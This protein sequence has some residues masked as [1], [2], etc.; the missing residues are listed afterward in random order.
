MAALTLPHKRGRAFL[1]EIE[2]PDIVDGW[3]FSSAVRVGA[4][5]QA[6]RCRPIHGTRFL[7]VSA[8]AAE[9]ALWPIG[10]MRWDCVGTGAD[11]GSA[12]T[13]TVQITVI[14]EVAP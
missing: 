3:A 6:L 5:V 4:F 11:G 9:T 8:S 1:V 2:W 14:P 7:E 13:P 12:A 10:P